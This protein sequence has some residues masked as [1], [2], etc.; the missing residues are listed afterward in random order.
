MPRNNG[1]L[2]GHRGSRE[3]SSARDA[4]L[5]WFDQ[6]WQ[7]NMPIDEVIRG[8]NDRGQKQFNEGNIRWLAS[9]RGVCRPSLQNRAP[10]FDQMAL[11]SLERENRRK[12]R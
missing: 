7:A 6:V 10:T 9:R 2:A 8:L 4:A 3:A 11:A 12:S 1:F 5:E